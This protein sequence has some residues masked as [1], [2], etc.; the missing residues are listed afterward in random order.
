M[1][2]GTRQYSPEQAFEDS[3]KVKGF[4][5]SEVGGGV[6]SN[7]M[8]DIAEFH[9][10]GLSPEQEKNLE[11]VYARSREELQELAA[12]GV[13]REIAAKVTSGELPR[14]LM[15]TNDVRDIIK[16]VKEYTAYITADGMRA[17]LQEKYPDQQGNFTSEQYNEA[18]LEV[19]GLSEEDKT[20]I[21]ELAEELK[22]GIL[23][24]IFKLAKEDGTA[25]MTHLVRQGVQQS[26]INFYRSP[27][28]SSHADN[29]ILYKT[30][31]GLDDEFY[32][33]GPLEE[34][35]KKYLRN[36]AFYGTG[37]HDLLVSVSI[38]DEMLVEAVAF[39]FEGSS[40]RVRD[41]ERP[42]LEYMLGAHKGAS[43]E[44]IIE[45]S[46]TLAAI[47]SIS[48]LKVDEFDNY[49]SAID[50]NLLLAEVRDGDP[51]VFGIAESLQLQTISELAQAVRDNEEYCRFLKES[52][53]K[54]IFNKE[55]LDSISSLPFNLKECHIIK[56][57]GTDFKADFSEEDFKHIFEMLTADKRLI[58]WQDN[59]NIVEPFKNS[60]EIFGYRQMFSYLKRRDASRHDMLSG[61]ANIMRMHVG[62]GLEPKMFFNNI[63][64]EVAMD[65]GTYNDGKS[66]DYLNVISQNINLNTEQVLSE[67]RNYRELE[68]LQELVD[69][70]E[71]NSVF[72]S[73][74]SLRKYYELQR[75]LV[76]RHL[77]ED[78]AE[79]KATGNEKLYHYVESLAFH[80]DSDV[81][82][83]TAIQLWRDP[84]GFL[85]LDDDHSSGLHERKKPSNYV[86]I[87]YL[88][89]SPTEL[90]D[91]LVNGDLD[92]IQ[93]FEPFEV[94]Y[95]IPA[96]LD[97]RTQTELGYNSMSFPALILT[98]LGSREKNIKGKAKN[99]Q[100]LFKRI[101]ALLK[102][103]GIE[104]KKVI[105]GEM[106]CDQNAEQA[107]KDL[108]F[109]PEIGIERQPVDARS[110]RAKIFLKSDPQAVAAGNDTA[111]C[112]YFGSGKNNV[113]TFNPNCSMFII[114]EQK[115]DGKWRTVC[116]S[117]LTEDA[118]INQ[119]IPKVIKNFDDVQ[120][121][122]DVLESNEVDLDQ[123]IVAADN[124]EVAKNY[125]SNRNYRQIIEALY[126]DFFRKYFEKYGTSGNLNTDSIVIGR[127]YSDAL[128]NLPTKRNTFLPKAPVAY[129]DNDHDTCY[130]LKLDDDHK[131]TY[132]ILKAEVTDGDLVEHPRQPL[133][134]SDLPRLQYLTHQDTLSVA[135]L[136]GKAYAENESLREYLFDLEN[137]LIAKDINNV[138][139]GRVNLSLKWR[140]ENSRTKGYLI[141][142]EGR[143]EDEPI[144]YISDLAA[145]PGQQ[146]AGGQLIKGFVSLYKSEYLDKGN[147]IPIVLQAREQT[148]YQLITRHIEA[149]GE[150]AGVRFEIQEEGT[151]TEGADTMHMLRIIPH[152][153]G[154]AA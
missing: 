140:D 128:S 18:E 10:L 6:Y 61:M 32:Y 114:Q 42:R 102:P 33:S 48:D 39:G 107:I 106:A 86:E 97:E 27:D 20:R 7:E 80:P 77:F 36:T 131:P 81:N 70:F 55:E 14:E 59:D 23:G 84:E 121:Y 40:R 31:L 72:S 74:K 56:E 144:V 24:P 53:T 82:S 21:I 12:F 83:D 41:E 100:E 11:E 89:L 93:A 110:Y 1:E 67:A 139:K 133:L 29:L 137:S 79:L 68:T 125:T 120:N 88:D 112:M 91:A 95:Q 117:V 2:H 65:T 122:K 5:D 153:I 30:L 132:P 85:D 13:V 63:L 116:Q 46:L 150:Q 115:P 143:D 4:L 22:S 147:L 3:Q 127:G 103:V 126:Y 119:D 64:Q 111:C 17:Y 98:A 78:L 60:A 151:R 99:P 47:N 96:K 101:N 75:K 118:D 62:S 105:N 34:P 66:Y 124:C 25:Q 148:S 19:L 49:L 87:P 15:D 38:P 57:A 123:G 45:R 109:D 16:W 113:Y 35:F 134:P 54:C 92:K 9:A 154:D 146:L 130:E 152:E 58:D 26:L 108:V 28:S 73:W 44:K 135:I 104:L 37:L 8:Y 76:K 129:T 142:Y 50:P 138:A 141:A 149:L 90:R 71:N 69:H 136:E 51:N 43:P 145:E 52:N 94:D